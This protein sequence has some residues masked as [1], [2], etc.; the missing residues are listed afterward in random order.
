M[1]IVSLLVSS[2]PTGYTVSR[3]PT[4]RSWSEP[5]IRHE[6][7]GF[8][9]DEQEPGEFHEVRFN[10]NYDPDKYEVQGCYGFNDYGFEYEI[11]ED[12]P[13][14]TIAENYPTTFVCVFNRI[15]DV[16]TPTQTYIFHENVK[17]SQGLTLT[18]DP[19]DADR[20]VRF[21]SYNP[22]GTMTSLPALEY[23][24]VTG[25]EIWDFENANTFMIW[26]DNYVY[27]DGFGPVPCYLTGSAAYNDK[28]TGLL[29]EAVFD[30]KTNAVSDRVHFLQA[31]Y[32]VPQDPDY[33]LEYDW[34]SEFF[35]VPLECSGV[36]DEDITNRGM[37]YHTYSLDGAFANTPGFNSHEVEMVSK[38]ISPFNVVNGRSNHF[39]VPIFTV[40][41]HPRFSIC[42]TAVEN[43]LLYAGA[44][45]A[46]IERDHFDQELWMREQDGIYAPG[47]IWTDG[48]FRH[49]ISG[50]IPGLEDNR[51]L[52]SWTDGGAF[53]PGHAAFDSGMD[54]MKFGASFPICAAYTQ[55]MK[56]KDGT[57]VYV[58]QPQY[59]GTRGEWRRIDLAHLDGKVEADGKTLCD[60]Y[61]DM[62][63]WAGKWASDSHDPTKVTATF[64]N[65]N[66]C[67]GSMDG[68]SI[69]SLTYDE[70]AGDD[71][72]APT[73]CGLQIVDAGGLTAYEFNNSADLTIRLSA[74]DFNCTG[75]YYKRVDVAGMKV[76]IAPM[77]T[78]EYIEVTMT[79]D[80]SLK[81]AVAGFGQYWEGTLSSG[82]ANGWYN[83]RVSLADEVG[84]THTQTISP[85]FLIGKDE[86]GIDVVVAGTEG[87]C[88]IFNLQGVK[89]GNGFGSLPAGVYV[90]RD[91]AG[92]V[93]KRIVR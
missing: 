67:L 69:T 58:F 38:G 41:D 13:V 59:F 52:S 86:G 19:A 7:P 93:T 39:I 64:T 53:L 84:N 88:D 77:A 17:A 5:L 46:S 26:I 27:V 30:Y 72:S 32:I 56:K 62:Y 28:A 81:N 91:S 57:P 63:S 87:S 47:V 44:V 68:I 78:D 50:K 20:T 66:W 22:D 40:G 79:E 37:A 48:A 36:P 9:P 71:R 25:E 75:S 92:N 90:V 80:E 70:T 21:R 24:P 11:S 4:V 33:F 76:E 35:I 23:D 1:S 15:E 2:A 12:M 8:A 45:P 6:A 85:A 49:V 83:L 16:F 60:N 31:R 89:V 51:P 73:V 42:E 29:N 34:A 10:F 55:I 74:A 61:D 43:P 3:K 65:T 82:L 18:F 14:A 54:G